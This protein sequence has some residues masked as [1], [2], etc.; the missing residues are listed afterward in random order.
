MAEQLLRNIEFKQRASI[1]NDLR[2][3]ELL[4]VNPR[5]EDLMDF[6]IHYHQ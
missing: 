4:S 6:G 5:Q 1:G 2:L 3:G